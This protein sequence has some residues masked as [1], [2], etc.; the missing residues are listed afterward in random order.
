MQSDELMEH[1]SAQHPEE[2][3]AELAAIKKFSPNPS[4]DDA[5]QFVREYT[6][7]VNSAEF[8]RAV[9]SKGGRGSRGCGTPVATVARKADH[10]P[11]AVTTALQ[12]AKVT[13]KCHLNPIVYQNRFFDL[14]PPGA[15]QQTGHCHVR[16]KEHSRESTWW[17]L[18]N[19][20]GD[21]KYEGA[22]GCHT[23]PLGQPDPRTRPCAA[24]CAECSMTPAQRFFRCM[25]LTR[26]LVNNRARGGCP[27]RSSLL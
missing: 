21:C 4:P 19:C 6:S 14:S 18:A 12:D 22:K 13:Q 3:D 11:K 24:R 1:T 10:D 26:Y 8:R 7:G 20:D 16:D 27:S 5:T 15:D 25:K 2:H 17:M 23:V 9:A